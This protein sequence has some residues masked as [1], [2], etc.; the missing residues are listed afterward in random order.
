MN[1]M[2]GAAAMSIELRMHECF[3]GS[4]CS[5]CMMPIRMR[6][7]IPAPLNSRALTGKLSEVTVD[8]REAAQD[9]NGDLGSK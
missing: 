5:R 9:V 3:E 8:D 7:S 6:I 2:W 4:I 1:H